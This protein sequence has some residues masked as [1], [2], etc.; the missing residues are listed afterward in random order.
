[1]R[2]GH[3][4]FVLC[5]GYKSQLIKKYFLDYRH[6]TTD[7]TLHLGADVGPSVH[8]AAAIEDWEITFVE[9]GLMTGTG[10]RIR[11]VADHLTG[12]RFA[13][14]YGDGIGDVDISALHRAHL[15]AGTTATV[16][17]VRPSSRYGEMMVRDSMVVEFNE[18]PA[19]AEGWVN[20][21]FF[22]FER[23]FVDKYVDEEPDI[24]LESEPLRQLARDQQLSVF[25]HEGFWM[26]MD[27]FRDWTE[28]N[29]RWDA[30]TAP[31]KVWED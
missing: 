15:E 22:F 31:W 13:L 7:F 11:R 14:T 26:G 25:G 1:M 21:G 20:G 23:D 24:M 5:L 6:L 3:R 12:P 16:T 19:L 10:A 30:G 18:K 4:K 9:T 27:T 29:A 17:G 8:G 2:H 28:L